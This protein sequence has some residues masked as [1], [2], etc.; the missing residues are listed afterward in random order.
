[1]PRPRHEHPT[2][3]E[4]EVLKILWDQGPATVR[5]VMEVLN[6]QRRRAYTS[7]MSLLGVMTEKH[8][9][10]TPAER[11]GIPLRGPRGPQKTVGQMLHDLLAR[12]LRARRTRWWPNCWTNR[13][14]RHANW[15]KSARPSIV[16]AKTVEVT[17]VATRP[18]RRFGMAAADLD[19]AALP[20]AGNAGGRRVESLVPPGSGPE[21]ANALL[22]GPRRLAGHGRLPSDDHRS[23][24]LRHQDRPNSVERRTRGG[25]P[26]SG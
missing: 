22:A 17:N 6:R 10:E 16:F 20:L 9:V 19:V 25:G 7:V 8:L 11:P 14:R 26:H 13:A 21:H 2:P 1:M 4:L 24:H 3:A 15:R 18:S 23:R 5:Q 12:H